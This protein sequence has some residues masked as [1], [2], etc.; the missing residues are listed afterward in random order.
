MGVER[1]TCDVVHVGCLILLM[2][3]VHALVFFVNFTKFVAAAA[4]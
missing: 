3:E 2:C 1:R 4:S